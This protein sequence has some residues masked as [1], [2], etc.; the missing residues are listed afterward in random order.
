MEVSNLRVIANSKTGFVP[1]Q[2]L[3]EPLLKTLLKN[4]GFPYKLQHKDSLESVRSFSEMDISLKLSGVDNRPQHPNT[5]KKTDRTSCLSD[6]V[7]LLSKSGFRMTGEGKLCRQLLS[8]ELRIAVNHHRGRIGVRLMS[9]SQAYEAML[10]FEKFV[11]KA[12][13]NSWDQSL[14]SR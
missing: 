4:Y 8:N 10:Y 5:A 13:D 3:G 6:V 11:S 9:Q 2:K 14:R 1:L 12:S 7:S